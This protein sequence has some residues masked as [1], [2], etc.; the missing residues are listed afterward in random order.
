MGVISSKITVNDAMS[1]A[2]KSMSSALNI[3]ISNF[4]QLQKAS[5]RA[6]DTSSIQAARNY[7]NQAEIGFNQVE[8]EIK[9]VNNQQERLNQNLSNGVNP[10]KAF[11]Q[12]MLGLSV[13][14]KTLSLITSGID[15]AIRRYD[16]LNNYTS[17][18]GN[19]GVDAGS[20]EM[21]KQMLSEGLK[22]L[23]TTLDSAVSSVQRFTS[24]NGNIKA[25]TN[26]FLA[27]NNALLAG[28][29][30]AETQASALEQ[31][32][33]AYS[34]GK[35]DQMEWKAMLNA[36]PAQITQ[37]AK[38]MNTT[39]TQLGE[40]LRSGKV[41]MGEF[42]E[43]IQRLNNEGVDGM[44]SFAEQAKDAT[45]GIGTSLANMYS[46]VTRG[47][48]TMIKIINTS[49]E[50]A[51]LGAISDN[52]SNFGSS[53]ENVL[54]KAGAFIGN[55]ITLLEPMF[56][57]IRNIG[58]FIVDNWSLIAPIITGIA[59]AV[60]L[61][62]VALSAHA[63]WVGIS[64]AAE[65]LHSIAIYAQAKALLANI[66]MTL[67]ATSTE[68]ALAVA[69]AQ[70]TVAQTGFN[71]ALLACPL[72]WIIIAIIA[73]IALIFAVVAAINKV[74]GSS[75]SAIGLI[76]GALYVA[77]AIIKNQFLALLELVFAIIEWFYN[78]WAAFAN[79]FANVFNDPI[80]SIIHLFGDLGDRVLGVI[81][82]IA[83]AIDFVF[84]SNLASTVSGWRNSLKSLVDGAV[85]KYGNGQYEEVYEKLDI[86]T[87]LSDVGINL[88]RSEYGKAWDSGYDWGS[89]FQDNLSNMFNFNDL[90]SNLPDT[91]AWNQMNDT[92][93]ALNDAANSGAGNA[94]KVANNTQD[95][96][97][98]LDAT[99]E[100][101]KYL[102]DLAEQEIINRFTTAEI[103]IDMTNNN[104][105][106]SGMDI[107]GVVSTLEE[108]LQESMQ[109]AAEGYHY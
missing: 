18:M 34:K 104:S 41:S 89:N 78:G 25:S 99:E 79:F 12:G 76:T 47:I 48:T 22:G 102:R 11:V 84:G 60:G 93:N 53:L 3:V 45:K 38:A 105:I 67:L 95:I 2:L 57:L 19:L 58:S 100:D 17:I 50:K 72:T 71:A 73:I 90:T 106:N 108:K 97:N 85:Q 27:L 54:N 15:N 77:G 35:P 10:A 36:M 59:V 65:W 86:D 20:A 49:M 74:T 30:S 29:T 4:E 109:V 101:L 14:Q 82:K 56:N 40:D 68:Y 63:M 69:T 64:T 43:T 91:T 31:I 62:N 81:Q 6:V 24:A 39:A 61:Y 32:S 70:A 66:N 98:K 26:M 5:G 94:G 16:T 52:I 107:D 8:E 9:N 37:I 42:F 55:M 13:V 88:E 80:G 83:E 46:A 87:W 7:L 33:Q 28:G 51:G 75:T 21:S 103:K 1:P 44:A 96:S 92:A 23:P